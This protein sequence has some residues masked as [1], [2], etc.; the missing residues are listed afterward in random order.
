MWNVAAVRSKTTRFHVGK[1][2]HDA[3]G[4]VH[5][6]VRRR[7]AASCSQNCDSFGWISLVNKRATP[8]Q[9]HQVIEACKYFFL[10]AVD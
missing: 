8:S 7:L 1:D 6:R 2:M 4:T 9:D 3:F 5:S 10:W